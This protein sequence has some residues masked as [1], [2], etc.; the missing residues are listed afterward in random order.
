MNADSLSVEN[1]ERKFRCKDMVRE[2]AVSA[3]AARWQEF[4][5]EE[6]FYSKKALL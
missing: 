1:C 2:S 5:K 4:G 3:G 6:Q